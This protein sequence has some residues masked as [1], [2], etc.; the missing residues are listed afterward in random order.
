MDVLHVY[1]RNNSGNVANIM[2]SEVKSLKY[3]NENNIEISGDGSA[4]TSGSLIFRDTDGIIT[5]STYNDSSGHYI[6]LEF[7]EKKQYGFLQG[8]YI[9][10]N[11]NDNYFLNGC[12]IQVLD[13]DKTIIHESNIIS[14]SSMFNYLFY[15]PDK[16]AIDICYNPTLD[17]IIST[18]DNTMT[19]AAP[20]SSQSKWYWRYCWM[21]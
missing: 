18:V 12:S 10:Q 19:I 2:T 5:N 6:E 11:D 13:E 9:C 17:E 20:E 3:Y 14:V 7:F 16:N 8:I 15:G 4:G 21:E 1:Q